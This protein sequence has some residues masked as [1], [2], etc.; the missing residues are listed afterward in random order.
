MSTT[1]ADELTQMRRREPFQPFRVYD[2]DG[3]KYEVLNPWEVLVTPVLVVLPV[4]VHDPKDP[5]AGY[6]AFVDLDKVDRIESLPEGLMEEAP[7]PKNGESMSGVDRQELLRLKRQEPFRPFQLHVRDGRVLAI[8]DPYDL[9]VM[10]AAVVVG[11]PDP[12]APGDLMKGKV[13]LLLLE[14][15]LRLELLEPTSSVS[16]N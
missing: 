10:D 14:E 6:P 2:K 9:M 13:T 5:D 4:R 7:S 8:R 3:E 16:S 1:M 11:T 12:E 15:I